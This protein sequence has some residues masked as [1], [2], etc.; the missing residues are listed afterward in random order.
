MFKRLFD[1][2]CERDLYEALFFSFC[3]I[4]FG[5]YITG[6]LTYFVDTYP[7]IYRYGDLMLFVPFI[8]YTS[9]SIGII[10]KKKLKDFRSISLILYITAL[11][12]FVPICLGVYFLYSKLIDGGIKT[13]LEEAFFI[14]FFPGLISGCIPVTI[15]S[16][17]ENH[18]LKKMVQEMEQEKLEHERWVEK[19]LLT[20]RAI[21][22]KIEEIKKHVNNLEK[23]EETNEKE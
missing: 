10:S 4:I 13:A 19:Q 16:T 8:F 5:Y 17:K 18:S 11:T 12:L 22:N 2:S 9:I 20:E 15:L 23:K 14:W 3:Y 7:F 1:L 6:I 21:A